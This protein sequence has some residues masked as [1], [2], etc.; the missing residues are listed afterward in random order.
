[1][2]MFLRI[3]FSPGSRISQDDSSR[4]A[5]LVP[6]SQ[7]AS[8]PFV[9]GAFSFRFHHQ[10][11]KKGF[12]KRLQNR[13]AGWLGFTPPNIRYVVLHNIR[14][15]CMHNTTCCSTFEI[16]ASAKPSNNPCNF[17]RDCCSCD[18][19][20]FQIFKIQPQIMRGACMHIII[21]VQYAWHHVR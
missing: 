18:F 7:H 21:S 8:N 20:I 13:A 19:H 2:H 15:T 5:S 1:M 17:C 16:M 14:Y 11:F 3:P 9:A 4:P 6:G 10:G 12:Q